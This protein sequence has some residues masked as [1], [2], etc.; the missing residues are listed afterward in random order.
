MEI[1]EVDEGKLKQI[2]DIAKISQQQLDDKETRDFIYGFIESYNI[3]KTE[4]VQ[5]TNSV[6][7]PP[8]VP[9]RQIPR[10]APAPPSVNMQK[11]PP[12]EL[13]TPREPPSR[14]PPMK[15]EQATNIPA[16]PPMPPPMP[17]LA[18]MQ[19]TLMPSQPFNKYDYYYNCLLNHSESVIFNWMIFLFS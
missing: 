11:R 3:P 16:P 8:P 19:S 7:Q 1:S 6:Q 18:Q 12:A 14:P 10:M 15:M 5:Q 4:N 13:P 9:S 17:S 2:F